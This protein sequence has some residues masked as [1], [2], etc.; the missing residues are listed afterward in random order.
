M[1]TS[2]PPLS[3]NRRR[4]IYGDGIWNV[5]QRKNTNAYA[6]PVVHCS[7][8]SSNLLAC[9]TG[10]R[11]LRRC[12]GDSNR[13]MAERKPARRGVADRG[14]SATHRRQHQYSRMAGNTCTAS[15]SNP[16]F[17]SVDDA[18]CG[19]GL[20][21]LFR[22][23]DLFGLGALYYVPCTVLPVSHRTARLPVKHRCFLRGYMLCRV[24][25]RTLRAAYIDAGTTSHPVTRQRE[26]SKKERSHCETSAKKARSSTRNTLL[27]DNN[28]PF[29]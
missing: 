2:P 18:W 22:C 9:D 12:S 4:T 17:C 20:F 29:D 28:C 19:L 26:T 10:M 15:W 6:Y 23:S 5:R 11:W 27:A 13:T 1:P 3:F 21:V 8:F 25:W 7:V 14:S 24:S 16:N